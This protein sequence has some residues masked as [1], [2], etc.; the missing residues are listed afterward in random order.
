MLRSLA[1]ILISIFALFSCQE[2]N[3]T[4]DFD[5][6]PEG[7]SYSNSGRYIPETLMPYRSGQTVVDH[8]NYALAYSETHEQAE[9]AAYKLTPEQVNNRHITRKNYF[10]TDPTTYISSAKHS[11]YSYTG[12]A[13]GHLVPATHMAYDL[14]AYKKT[15][16]MSNMSPQIQNGFNAG[17]WSRLETQTMKWVTNGTGEKWVFT[18][19]ILYPGLP[20]LTQYAANSSRLNWDIVTNISVPQYFYKIIY[21]PDEEWVIAFIFENRPHNGRESFM[22]Y[23]T[24]VD[25][26]ESYTGIDFLREV[27]DEMENWLESTIDT[28]FWE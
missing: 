9:W 13:R 15:F 23:V 16:Y 17:I 27:E 6:I 2:N 4:E 14:T 25:A 20:K 5:Y 19:P 18:G 12:Y 1:L 7:I 22:E 21:D 3:Y 10:K 11:D 8:G 26:I 24:T 28:S